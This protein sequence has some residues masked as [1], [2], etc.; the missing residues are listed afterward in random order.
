MTSKYFHIG[1]KKIT[2]EHHT[3][4]DK[5]KIHTVVEAEKIHKLDLTPM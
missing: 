4:M 1:K 5:Y 3:G 2:N